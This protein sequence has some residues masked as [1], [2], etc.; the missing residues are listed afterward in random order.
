MNFLTELQDTLTDYPFVYD[1]IVIAAALLV[2]VAAG[3]IVKNGLLKLCGVVF[4]KL[5]QA[6]QPGG[7]VFKAVMARIANI[8]PAVVV[9]MLP[10]VIPDCSPIL[11]EVL[12]KLSLLFIVVTVSLALAKLIDLIEVIYQRQ[13]DAATKPIKGYLQLVKIFI[14]IVALILMGSILVERSPLLL[15]S[16]VGAMAA[17]LMLIFQDTILSVVAGVQL[18]SNQMVR[19]GDWIEMPSQNADGAVVE[20]ALHT[21][22]VQNWD[23]TISTVPIRKLIT[24]SF[25]NWRG[26]FESGGRRIKRSLLIDQRSVRFLTE[27][28]IAHLGEFMLLAPYLEGKQA[29]LAEWNHELAERGANAA[30]NG[31]RLTNI[32]TFRIYIQ[33]YLRAH[34]G[35]NQELLLLVRQL[36]P[37]IS[38]L[39]LEVYC[40]TNDTRWVVYEQ[41]QSD[42]FDHLLAILP[43]FGLRVFQQCSDTSGIVLAGQAPDNG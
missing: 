21:V 10:A 16:G 22:K 11:Q 28:E 20:I 9:Y 35:V 27:E 29:E 39:P 13:P 18:G 43:T 3:W 7:E 6:D 14:V 26:M 31:R 37:G 30:V 12:R 17:V 32:G 40:F 34:P 2:G 1:A 38:G 4:R 23:K 36:Q 42:I 5:P 24:D 15:L 8:V 25:I 41:I 33:Q 19:I